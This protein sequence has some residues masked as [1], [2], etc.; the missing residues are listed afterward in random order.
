MSLFFLLNNCGGLEQS[1]KEKIRKANEVAEGI[2]RYHSET[3]GVEIPP[4]PRVREKYPWEEKMIGDLQRI[5]KEHF[6]CQ[7]RTD[8]PMQMIKDA[9][10]KDLCLLDCGGID[11]HSLPVLNETEH[12]YP[13]LIDLLNFVQE[14]VGCKVVITC[15]H[16][17]PAH[18]VY[19][20]QRREAR[21]SKH[22][23]GAEVDFYVEGM[24]ES[25]M[26]VVEILQEFYQEDKTFG[27]LNSHDR[28]TFSN[29]E[30][31]VRIYQKGEG[32]DFDNQH[33]HPYLSIEV[34][35]DRET[36]KQVRYNWHKAYNG[37]LRW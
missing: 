19:A 12:I 22:L 23:V 27:M 21:V 30:V 1:E 25:P 10:G 32:R 18:N 11:R 33:P 24:E 26:E 36:N 29:A 37:Y 14:R 5:T 15:G 31:S 6:R 9:Q 3:F 28:N 2:Y 7:G 35:K 34:L 17:C 20:D 13:I 4:T 8:H 16:R